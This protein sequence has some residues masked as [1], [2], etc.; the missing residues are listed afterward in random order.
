MQHQ[1]LLESTLL[2]SIALPLRCQ[3]CAALDLATA[4]DAAAAEP[5]PSSAVA[6]AAAALALAAAALALAAAAIAVKPSASASAAAVGTTTL[7]AVHGRAIRRDGSEN[8]AMR[9]VERDCKKEE[10]E[11]RLSHLGEGKVL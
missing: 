7:C 3:R 4:A 6:L 1:L 9:H 2:S 8:T 5:E 10:I 11:M